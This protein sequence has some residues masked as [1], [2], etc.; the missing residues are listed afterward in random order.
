MTKVS[1]ISKNGRPEARAGHW[2]SVMGQGSKYRDGQEERSV[3][4]GG[5]PNR[6][7]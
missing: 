1:G 2:E 5:R 6:V 3:M 4:P 7:L